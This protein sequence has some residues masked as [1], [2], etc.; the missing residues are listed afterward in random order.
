MQFF[1]SCAGR[2]TLADVSEDIANDLAF[3]KYLKRLH[4][5]REREKAFAANKDKEKYDYE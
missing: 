5:Q 2:V 4:E 1:D 3:E